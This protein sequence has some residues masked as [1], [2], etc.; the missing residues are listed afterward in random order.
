[1]TAL[2]LEVMLPPARLSVTSPCALLPAW[3]VPLIVRF[4]VVF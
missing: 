1:M 4:W 2:A 3:T